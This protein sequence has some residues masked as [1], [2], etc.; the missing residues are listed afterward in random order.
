[1]R[2]AFLKAS[3]EAKNNVLSELT[4]AMDKTREKFSA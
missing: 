4:V 3:S 1:M 2:D